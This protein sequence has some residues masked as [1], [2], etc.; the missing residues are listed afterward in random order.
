MIKE[1]NFLYVLLAFLIFFIASIYITFP[2]IFH[3]GNFA[4]GLGDELVIS[5]IQNWVIHSVL[6]NPFS[7]LDANIYYPYQ[8]SLA[9]SD[10]FLTSSILAILPLKIIGEPIV[11]V[12]VTLISS[13]IML[14]FFLYLLIQFLTKDF[15]LS[16]LGGVLIIFSPVTLD[17][18]VHIQVLAIQWVP[19]SILFFFLFI[20]NYR[21]RYLVLSLLFFVL[22]TYNSF[23]P[24]YFIFF[25]YLIILI[26]V[27]F[28]N[29]HSFNLFFVKKNM[30]ITIV[31]FVLL[32]PVALPYYQVSREFSYVRDIREAIHFA[33][34]PQDLLYPNQYSRLQNDLIKIFPA[35]RLSRNGYLGF[36]F[37][38]LSA[39][40]LVIFFI[41]FKKKEIIFNSFIVI[42]IFGLVMSFGPALHWNG[43]TIHKP[44]PIPLPYALFYYIFPGFQGLRNSARWEML[45]ALM[46]AVSICLFLFSA[47]KKAK[48]LTRVIVYTLLIASVIAEYNYPMKFV[49]VVQTKDFPKVYAWLKHLPGNVKIIEMPV[50]NWNL[51]PFVSSERTRE[52]YSAIHF[53]KMVNGASGFSPPPWQNMVLNLLANFPSNETMNSLRSMNINY[54]IVHK[55]EYD[56]LKES[57][58][59]VNGKSIKDGDTVIHSLVTKQRL[60]FIKKF[61]EDYVF[62]LN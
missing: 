48:K 24:G 49:K 36:T 6:T 16:I 46:M 61:D 14:G 58:L 15:L 43:Q 26:H 33:L 17:K 37:S 2:L 47:S 35:N 30:V 7:I 52:Y 10:L 50:Y 62:E 4:T 12:N 18:I 34:Q 31:F 29:R 8:N 28:Y 60:N 44:L 20:K 9:F 41:K 19:L 45:F 13:L 40:I 25:S 54:I 53:K 56:M 38:V 22:Q 5:W 55:K 1:K 59:L 27:F 11:A 57:H 32:I 42:A 51:Q 23:L 39:V 21:T 3:L